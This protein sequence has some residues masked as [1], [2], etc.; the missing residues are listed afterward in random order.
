MD[1]AGLVDS[2]TQA[3]TNIDLGRKGFA[4]KGKAEEGRI[5]Y[6]I[7]IGDALSAFKE[8]QV[9]ADPQIF[10]LEKAASFLSRLCS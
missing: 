5:S 8:A 7:G 1:R 2:I 10:I 3:A 4:T 9:S 6:E